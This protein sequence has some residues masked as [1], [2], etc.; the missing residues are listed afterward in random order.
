VSEIW[1]QEALDRVA[2][3]TG[4][5]LTAAAAESPRTIDDFEFRIVGLDSP[6]GV[7]LVP[8]RTALGIGLRASWD[9]FSA[10]LLSGAEESF[11]AD[12]SDMESM[13]ESA[14]IS[15][16]FTIAVNGSNPVNTDVDREWTSVELTW[17]EPTDN[18]ADEWRITENMLGLAF[19]LLFDLL[20]GFG[21]VLLAEAS[22]EEEGVRISST[23]GRYRRSSSNRAECLR[24]LGTACIGCG[25]NPSD[26][27]GDEGVAIIH[28]H[29]L[30]PLSAMETPRALSP[31]F[32]LVPLCPNC[33]NFAHKRVPPF[34]PKEI[35][36]QLKAQR[37]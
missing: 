16:N 14:T 2:A 34:T 27:Y 17:F 8:F 25:M 19:P 15:G 10:D 30:T 32:D 11:F 29:H 9:L 37:K 13:F 26:V 21:S 1:A 35:R 33:H 23:C 18:A 7:A 22:G 24:R 5:S 6:N 28:V 3:I 12:R 36:N 31:A 4:L 20:T